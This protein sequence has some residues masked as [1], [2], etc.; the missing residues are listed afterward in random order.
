MLKSCVKREACGSC[1][2]A[3]RDIIYRSR[4]DAEHAQPYVSTKETPPCTRARVPRAHAHRGRPPGAAPKTSARP[5]ASRALIRHP[6]AGNGRYAP[7]PAYASEL[8][9]RPD[10]CQ[11]PQDQQRAVDHGVRT[12]RCR[13]Y[14]LR[15]CRKQARR[16]RGGEEP[17]ETK[18]SRVNTVSRVPKRLA[19]RF[20]CTASFRDGGL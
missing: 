16:Q 12:R 18:A 5:H 7:R 19:S 15:A 2:T 4:P 14:A 8:R 17:G 6:V 10:A 20:D 1:V 9:L 13:A 3:L 11:G